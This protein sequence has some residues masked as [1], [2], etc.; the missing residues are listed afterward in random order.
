MRWKIAIL[1]VLILV[2][3]AGVQGYAQ[4]TGFDIENRQPATLYPTRGPGDEAILRELRETNRLLQQ[5]N[6]LLE[7]QNKLM[8]LRSNRHEK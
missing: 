2:M 7:E 1:F 3:L 5:Q 4:Y 8:R 6:R